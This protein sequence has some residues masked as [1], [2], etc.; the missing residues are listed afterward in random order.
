MSKT[1]NRTRSYYDTRLQWLR[2]ANA[3][4]SPRNGWIRAIRTAL[5]MTGSELA[6]RMGVS[7]STIVG[8]ERS[9]AQ[10]TIKLKTLQKAASALDCDVFYYLAPRT[11]LEES[12]REQARKKARQDLDR[13]VLSFLNEDGTASEDLE[14]LDELALHYVDEKGLWAD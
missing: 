14:L 5:G 11:T 3:Q 12:V 13:G 1:S 4:P 8:L 6:S 9:E 2:I 10:G 7:Q